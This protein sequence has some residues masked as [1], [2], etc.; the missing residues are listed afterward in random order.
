LRFCIPGEEE[1]REDRKNLKPH[2]PYVTR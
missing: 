1:K 2:F